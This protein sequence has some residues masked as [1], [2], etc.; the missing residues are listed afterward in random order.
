MKEYIVTKDI[1][2]IRSS[3]TA[4]TDDN[5]IGQLSAGETLYLT[6]DEIIGVM[7]QGGQTNI[8]KTDNLNR[9]VSLDGVRLKTYAD[10][11]A[12]FIADTN[13]SYLHSN[14]DDET[15]WKINWGFVDLELWK[16]WEQG[17]TGKGIS[18][19]VID[20]GIK[21]QLIGNSQSYLD[22]I[23]YNVADK[24]NVVPDTTDHGTNSAG[25]IIA[26]GS[27]GF[28]GI[29]P[30][31]Q[32]VMIKANNGQ[33]FLPDNVALALEYAKD[34][35]VDIVSLSLVTTTS[36]KL[37]QAIDDFLKTGKILLTANG[38]PPSVD[39][40][41][42][43]ASYSGTIAIGAYQ[44]DDSFNRAY[45]PDGS[46]SSN[47]LKALF[48]GHKLL[49]VGFSDGVKSFDMSSAATAFAC[50]TLALILCSLSSNNAQ[51]NNQNILQLL[52]NVCELISS[53][54]NTSNANEGFGILNPFMLKSALSQNP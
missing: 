28:Y 19:A 29:A 22:K 23:S 1:L 44:L 30:D 49:D 32:L 5:F 12:E 35:P 21:P 51:P 39:G 46:I 53:D 4:E 17:F 7:P 13:F 24:T 33:I 41:D 37:E 15:Q 42:M 10:K 43:P 20:T 9:V 45:Y 54:N 3:A 27:T 8:W 31:A 6:D 14:T 16:F 34:L 50:G 40:M 2:N 47:Y 52:P 25:L 18:V 48:P 26:N 38:D 36:P 11:K